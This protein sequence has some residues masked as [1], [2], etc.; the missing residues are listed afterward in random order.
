M[1]KSPSK[2]FPLRS[3]PNGTDNHPPTTH[4]IKNN[5]RG[6]AD[7][8]LA[9]SRL[10]P[11]TAQARM[12][13]EGLN[14]SDDSRGQPLRCI[15]FVQSYVCANFLQPRQSQRRPDDFYRHGGLSS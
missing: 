7:D 15:G 12:V 14:H 6:A 5:V 13:S 11:G 4:T 9:D 1:Q 8:Q 2:L 3:V 10:S